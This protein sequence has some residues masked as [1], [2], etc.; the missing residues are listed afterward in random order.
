MTRGTSIEN[1]Y[2]LLENIGRGARAHP[3][4]RKRARERDARVGMRETHYCGF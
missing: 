2:E 1:V 4:R 3:A